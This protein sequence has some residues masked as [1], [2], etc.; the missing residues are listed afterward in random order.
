[1]LTIEKA[2]ALAQSKAAPPTSRWLRVEKA[3]GYAGISRSFLYQILNARKVSSHM[4]GRVRLIDRESLDAFI[5]A[6]P[7]GDFDCGT[8]IAKRRQAAA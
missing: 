8:K 6:A 5:S 2:D 3:L 4:V 1:M 7:V